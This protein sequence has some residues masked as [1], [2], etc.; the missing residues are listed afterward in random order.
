MEFID[1]LRNLK[2]QLSFK[3]K[4]EV[5]RGVKSIV[6][7]GMGGSAVAG[8]IFKE[9]YSDKPVIT[10]DDYN[11]PKFVSSSTLVVAMSYSGST[12]ETISLARQAKS[13]KAHLVTIS[14]GGELLDYGDQR[15]KIP[16][17]DLQP[18][19]AP[20]YML[21]PLLNGFKIITPDE[22][23]RAYELIDG[24][25][26]DSAECLA[27]AKAMLKNESIPVIY[28]A[29]PFRTISYRWKTQFNE[30]S[31]VLGYANDFPELNH[32]DTLALAN[33][34]RKDNFYF[35]VFQSERERIIKRISV[36]SKITNS[37]FNMIKPKGESDIEKM[38]YLLHYG[39][40]VSF[41]LGM[42]RK[43]DPQEV[44]LL[45]RLKKDIL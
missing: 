3:E 22:T 34:Y 27:H 11:L 28:G 24:L 37:K 26:K 7:A 6:I 35:F 18:R 29:S 12:E 33:T 8:K 19:S 31:K 9:F 40:Y 20:V 32:N 5:P 45:S 41:H 44:S 2:E 36:T 4:L 15:I 23:C 10:S 38:F 42:L 43:V 16:R 13:K 25:D 30:N 21:M 1:E 14:S 39:D 17:S